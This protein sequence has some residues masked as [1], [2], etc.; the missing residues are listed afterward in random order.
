M[1]VWRDHVTMQQDVLLLFWVIF[2]YWNQTEIVLFVSSRAFSLS[3][4][5]ISLS[6][7]QCSEATWKKATNVIYTSCSPDLIFWTCNIIPQKWGHTK[8][9]TTYDVTLT[10]TKRSKAFLHIT[11]RKFSPPQEKFW[12]IVQL[13]T[14]AKTEIIY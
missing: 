10:H 8:V 3:T 7:Q 9:G 13:S 14:L 12:F 11:T 1:A 2:L 5:T 6:V 4:P